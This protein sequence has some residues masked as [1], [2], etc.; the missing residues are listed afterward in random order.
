MVRIT[1]ISIMTMVYEY[2]LLSF[3]TILTF[4]IHDF[5]L[6]NNMKNAFNN[7]LL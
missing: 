3:D 1:L 7:Y 4:L 6:Q 2:A 5:N